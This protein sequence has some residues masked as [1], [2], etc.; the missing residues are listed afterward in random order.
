MPV[1]EDKPA[2]VGP[3]CIQQTGIARSF[4]LGLIVVQPWAISSAARWIFMPPSTAAM[5]R[6][7]RALICNANHKIGPAYLGV[8]KR[9][10]HRS[11]VPDA[12]F[13]YDEGSIRYNSG[14]IEILL[15]QQHVTP[16]AFSS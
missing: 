12:A 9:V 2:F 8:V 6:S 7:C 16:W 3:Q 14:K 4:A 11:R 5:A 1:R 15:G 10:S 13:F